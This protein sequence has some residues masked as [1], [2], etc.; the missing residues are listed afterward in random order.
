MR[1][2]VKRKEK[3]V[4]LDYEDEQNKREEEN[5]MKNDQKGKKKWL[6]K[7]SGEKIKKRRTGKDQEKT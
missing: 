2:Y 3:L 6:K 5:K 7:F 1:K 4:N